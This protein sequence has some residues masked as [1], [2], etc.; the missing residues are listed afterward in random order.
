MTSLKIVILDRATIPTNIRMKP[1]L[2]P[3]SIEVFNHSD[4]GIV[5]SR[6]IDADIVITNKAKISAQEIQ[7]CSRLKLVAIAATGTDNVD[8]Q[9]CSANRVAVC[10]IRDYAATTVPEHTFALIFALQRSLAAYRNAVNAGRWL[11]AGQ[12]C[13]FD[14]PIRDLAGSKIGIVGDGVLGKATAHIAQALGMH[15]LMA[16]HKGRKEM[17][18]LY[19]PFERVL[20]ESDIITLH[21]P[22][23]D[24][25]RN[26]IGDAEF[27][28]MTR[29]PI[30]INTA[31]G[32]LVDEFA[33]ARALQAGQ[34]AGAGFDVVTQ[35]PLPANHPFQEILN[36]PG[37]I[38]T[39]HVAWA[40]KQAIQTL[41][42]Q[43]M[44]N[45]TA[46]VEGKPRNLVCGPFT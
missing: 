35:E 38:L 27:A 9:A 37:F 6:M 30:L 39:P 32:G 11:E 43:L 15:V 1:L 24:S 21:C 26:L 18:A 44:D 7:A 45:I 17:G 28:Q 14:Y 25:T 31:R 22:L 8:V 19:T 12:F 42:D 4:A 36:H 2:F 10:N 46:F 41:A 16:A 40:S 3:H 33:L 34:I 13:F 23:N 29:R 20:S 5:G